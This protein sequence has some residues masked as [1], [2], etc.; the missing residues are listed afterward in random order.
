ML[1]S[2]TRMGDHMAVESTASGPLTLGQILDRAFRL[3]RARASALILTAAVGWGPMAL[4]WGV[5]MGPLV[6]DLFGLDLLTSS[7]SE[8]DGAARSLAILGMSV[9]VFPLL[10]VL[11]VLVAQALASQVLG[12]L[13]GEEMTTRQAYRAGL[14]HFSR[15]FG[16]LFLQTMSVAGL[17][18]PVYC[19]GIV[20]FFV[21]LTG[22]AALPSENAAA[23]A[24][25]V[26]GFVAGLL[27]FAAALGLP[28]LSLLSRWMV[29]SPGIADQGWGALESLQRSWNLTRGLAWRSL[30]FYVLLQFLSVFFTVLL[31]LPLTA[32]VEVTVPGRLGDIIKGSLGY[33]PEILWQ[34]LLVSAVVLYYLDLRVRHESL[35]LDD[36]LRQLEAARVLVPPSTPDAPFAPTLGY[37]PATPPAPSTPPIPPMPPTEDEAGNTEWP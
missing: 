10:L 6:G 24:L 34:P 14:K 9:L 18:V 28:Y 27:V 8:A 5:L 33:L 36:R 26:A 19:C 16:S 30:G 23:S 29:A 20:V 3:Y 32:L 25:A 31:A 2:S 1:P 35:D 4:L 21:A 22:T 13:R 12:L 11:Y 17:T 7:E 15:Y 37:G